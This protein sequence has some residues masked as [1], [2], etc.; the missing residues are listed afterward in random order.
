MAPFLSIRMCSAGQRE[1]GKE[2]ARA[3]KLLR[4]V[5]VQSD[6]NTFIQRVQT[7]GKQ[8]VHCSF[9]LGKQFN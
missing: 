5:L 6:K 4:E 3:T 9:V 8:E 7:N 1:S 2:R